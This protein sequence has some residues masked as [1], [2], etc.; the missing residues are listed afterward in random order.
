[1]DLRAVLGCSV[2]RCTAVARLRRRA[3]LRGG[4]SSLLLEH[5]SEMALV[6]KAQTEAYLRQRQGCLGKIPEGAVDPQTTDIGPDGRAVVP[7]KCAREV[8]RVHTDLSRDRGQRERL[9]KPVVD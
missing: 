4:Q 6:E 2:R 9:A 5:S 8:R 7:S 1:M 3:E